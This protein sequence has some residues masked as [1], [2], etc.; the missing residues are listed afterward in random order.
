VSWPFFYDRGWYTMYIIY[1]GNYCY[2]S[3]LRAVCTMQIIRIIWQYGTLCKSVYVIRIHNYY[4]YYIMI[5]AVNGVL[6]FSPWCAHFNCIV[7]ICIHIYVRICRL[8][9]FIS[10]N[11]S[12]GI[13]GWTIFI[14]FLILIHAFVK[15][16]WLIHHRDN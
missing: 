1:S 13:S 4:I 15:T 16:H 3:K 2:T 12:V 11:F 9:G 7:V 14:F 5:W 8:F 6:M 10:V